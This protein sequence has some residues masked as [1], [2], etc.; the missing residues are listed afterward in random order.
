MNN[1]YNDDA[2]NGDEDFD[3]EATFQRHGDH[4]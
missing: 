1:G 3:F 4:V 2:K